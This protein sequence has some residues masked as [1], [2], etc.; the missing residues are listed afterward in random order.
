[1]CSPCKFFLRALKKAHIYLPPSLREGASVTMMEAIAASRVSVVGKCGG[2]AMLVNEDCG[3]L[4][5][6]TDHS[7]M[8]E[9]I[10][11]KL[12]SL[13]ED[14]E[15]SKM[16]G[17]AAR[18]RVKEKCSEYC[19][20]KQ[21]NDHYLNVALREQVVMWKSANVALLGCRIC[22]HAVAPTSSY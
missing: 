13:C 9:V 14:P 4:I 16:L 20:R 17:E 11:D 5:P 7:E 2:A 6:I 22:S 21:I 1:M 10:A 3:R 15:I 8:G 19:Y 12:R 18:L